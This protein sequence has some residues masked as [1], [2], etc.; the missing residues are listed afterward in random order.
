M[1]VAKKKVSAA[2]NTDNAMGEA[3]VGDPEDQKLWDALRKLLREKFRK[4]DSEQH[5]VTIPFLRALVKDKGFCTDAEVVERFIYQFQE[6]STTLVDDGFLTRFDQ[7]VLFLKGLPEGMKTKIYKLAKFDIAIPSS[8]TKNGSFESS[9]EAALTINRTTTDIG[10][11]DAIGEDHTEL[12]VEAVRQ[13]LTRDKA[14]PG[15]LGVPTAPAHTSVPAGTS[16]LEDRMAGIEKGLQELKLYQQTAASTPG[17]IP[18]AGDYRN[19]RRAG[20]VNMRGRPYLPMPGRTIGNVMTGANQ[21]ESS[22]PPPV[23]YR[24]C[25]WCEVNGH[26]KYQ[27]ADY[28]KSLSEKL[29][30]FVDQ[31]DQ[32]MRMGPAGAGGVIIP[33]PESTGMWQKEWVEQERKRAESL[34]TGGP[35]ARAARVSAEVRRL[36]VQEVK[37]VTEEGLPFTAASML[38]SQPG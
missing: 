27:C 21:G 18:Q 33:L 37:E 13:I 23:S 6:I 36:T 16:L 34:M 4:H 15:N 17:Q 9:V 35:G 1:K 28:G 24:G 7:V 22:M 19:Y 38:T 29:V 14:V 10:L 11:L 25:R 8:F 31:A 32:K 3:P 20:N 30:H 2:Q 26:L 5:Q 12:P